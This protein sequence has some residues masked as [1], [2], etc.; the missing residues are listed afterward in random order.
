[1][2]LEKQVD[3]M[4]Y[5]SVIADVVN[6]INAGNRH[7]VKSVVL[8]VNK[9][10]MEI[11]NVLLELGLI[12]G[13]KMQPK[14][15]V[16]VNMRFFYGHQIFYKLSLVSKPSKRVYW[17]MH[18]LFMEVDKQNALIYIVSTK[19]GLLIGSDCLWRSL[20]G[21]VLIKILL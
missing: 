18:R 16:I 10:T 8:F 13:F 4:N 1:M 14:N 2:V 9:N 5:N 12:R 15:K 21:E 20:T 17:N 6:R 11:I 7:R 3:N 19:K